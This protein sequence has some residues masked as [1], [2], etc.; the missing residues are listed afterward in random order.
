[1]KTH[2]RAITLN[3]FERR[4]PRTNGDYI[5]TEI[6]TAAIPTDAQV[7]FIAFYRQIVTLSQWAE[8][9]PAWNKKT[10]G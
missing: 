10:E 2:V 1:M 7:R 8:E 6:L 3:H 9:Y 5:D 4:I